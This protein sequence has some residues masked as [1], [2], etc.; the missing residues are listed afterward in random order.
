MKHPKNPII[1]QKIQ[2]Y[3]K[4]QKIN[5]FFQKFRIF[6]EEKKIPKKKTLFFSQYY[7]YAIQPELSSLAQ[8]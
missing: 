5:F 2:K 3:Q 7:E 6:E 4:F 1:C 8:S